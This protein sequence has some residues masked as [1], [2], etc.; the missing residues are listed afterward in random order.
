MFRGVDGKRRGLITVFIMD[1]RIVIVLRNPIGDALIKI[2]RPTI[3]RVIKARHA[4]VVNDVPATD[5]EHTFL[6]Q[7]LSIDG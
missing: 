1:D 4:Q 6:T 5:D 3:G 7:F 2:Y